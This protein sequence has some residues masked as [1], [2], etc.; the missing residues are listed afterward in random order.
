[1]IEVA[2]VGAGPYGLS[3]AAHFR[4]HGI[5]F[6]IFGPAMDSWLTH[7]PKGMMLKSDGFASNIYDPEGQFT[8]KQFCA[9]REIPYSD[10]QFPVSLETFTAYGLAFRE[11]LVPELEEKMVVGLE[12]AQHGF[13]LQLSSGEFVNARRV[14]LA[15]G[16]THFPYI[17]E[18]LANLPREYVSHSFEHREVDALRGRKVIVI[19]G[20]ASAIGLASL[21][22]AEGV[23]VELAAR[24]DS[25]KFHDAPD[26]MPRSWWQKIRYP[27]S[28]LGP[29]LRSRF[30]ADAPMLFHQFPEKMRIETVRRSLGPSG[31]WVSKEKIAGKVPLR[32]GCSAEFGE[33][34]GNKILLHLRRADGTMNIVR[35]DHVIAG[36]GYR[37]DMGRLTFLSPELRTQ[38]RTAG[39]S[40]TLSR[41]FESS[42]PGLHFVGLAAANSFGPL[43]RFA[44]GANFAARNLTRAITRTAARGHAFGAVPQSVQT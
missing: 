39:G 38:V 10:T 26:G 42:I 30:F 12:R 20:G 29:G 40:P 13:T 17:P 37:V 33:I 44:F 16:I 35:A 2:I 36:T 28:G 7:M 8:L 43:L 18:S 32:L 31:H 24:E 25:L 21:M 22:K 6:R 23:D 19:G 9:A 27:Q 5:P 3:L 11:R 4:H 15:V 14:V 34:Q 41:T 1:M